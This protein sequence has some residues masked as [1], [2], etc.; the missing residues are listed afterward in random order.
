MFIQNYI[1]GI[2]KVVSLDA[3][4][5]IK[6]ED[7]KKLVD[8][9]NKDMPRQNERGDDRQTR[10]R[11]STRSSRGRNNTKSYLYSILNLIQIMLTL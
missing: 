8:K 4:P 7:K 10:S 2:T 6:K 3:N 9:V 5:S 1:T 11:T